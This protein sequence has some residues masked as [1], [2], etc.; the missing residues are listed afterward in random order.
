MIFSFGFTLPA[1]TSIDVPLFGAVEVSRGLIYQTE[2]Q[3]PPG[4]AGLVGVKVFD[5]GHQIYPSNP[6]AWFVGDAQT[7][8]FPDSYLKLAEPWILVLS[9]YNSDET[10]PH[11]IYFRFGIADRDEFMARFLPTFGYKEIQAMVEAEAQKQSAQ[12]QAL[13]DNPFPWMRKDEGKA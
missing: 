7:I 9:G 5:H 13:M 6:G 1:N 2:I 4:C 11:T 12:K 8:A 10:Y 3:F